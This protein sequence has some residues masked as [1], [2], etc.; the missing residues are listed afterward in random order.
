MIGGKRFQYFWYST[1]PSGHVSWK[2]DQLVRKQSLLII[3]ERISV[4]IFTVTYTKSRVTHNSHWTESENRSLFQPLLNMWRFK[5]I[6]LER[7][8]FRVHFSQCVSSFTRNAIPQ[9]Y[10]SR[11]EFLPSW[12]K[13]PFVPIETWS[14][15]YNGISGKFHE[16]IVWKANC[17][18]NLQYGS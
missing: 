11:Q 2:S 17:E 3:E 12:T 7:L 13:R 14:E 1:S 8:R 18:K 9:Q 16:K 15:P 5:W 10:G 6:C 4:E